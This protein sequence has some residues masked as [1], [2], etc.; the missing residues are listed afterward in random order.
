VPG[1]QEHDEARVHGRTDDTFRYGPLA[2]HPLAVRSVLV[3]R[4]EV[5]DYQVRQ[6]ANGIDLRV[7]ATEP[8]DVPALRE[9]L[10]EALRSAGLADPQVEVSTTDRVD[11]NPASGKLRRFMPLAG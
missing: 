9:R 11:R 2:V 1:G 7:V 8:F 5:A 10:T 3:G 6:T 4:P